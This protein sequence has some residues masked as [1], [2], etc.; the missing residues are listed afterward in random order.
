MLAH[1]K[2]KSSIDAAI[3]VFV[4]DYFLSKIG[5]ILKN[6]NQAS[7]HRPTLRVVGGW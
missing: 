2:S 4:R 3:P 7:L 1:F 5:S 6:S